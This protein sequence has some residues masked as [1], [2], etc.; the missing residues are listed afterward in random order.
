[1]GREDNSPESSKNGKPTKSTCP[2]PS[3][4]Q[5]AERFMELQLLRQKVRAAESKRTAGAWQA[6][7]RS[8]R[9]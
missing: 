6:A 4:Q 3:R 5:L 1:M 8:Q 9:G 2:P 7:R